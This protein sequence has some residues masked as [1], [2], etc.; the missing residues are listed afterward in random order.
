M[1]TKVIVTLTEIKSYK[2]NCLAFLADCTSLWKDD[3][4]GGWFL[5]RFRD[6][7]AERID[8]EETRKNLRSDDWREVWADAV[9][10]MA[11]DAPAC[12]TD[13]RWREFADLGAWSEDATEL[14]YTDLSRTSL[15]DIA[16]VC[17][18]IIADR[19]C[20]ILLERYIEGVS[21]N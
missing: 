4:A 11:N 2:A 21:Q 3:S 5:I 12:Y 17:L 19:L 15:T 7:L 13:Q 14:G 9:H 1:E 10:E 18:Y 20:W 8:Y 16:G 6:S